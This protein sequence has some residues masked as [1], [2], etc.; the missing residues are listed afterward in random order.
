L[1]PARSKSSFII[2]PGAFASPAF[3]PIGLLI[4]SA[5]LD[6]SKVTAAFHVTFERRKTHSLPK[7]LPAPPAK[8]RKPYQALARECHLSGKAEGAFETLRTFAESIAAS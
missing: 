6:R 5:T 4:Q 8:W 1:S 7:V 3:M 2:T